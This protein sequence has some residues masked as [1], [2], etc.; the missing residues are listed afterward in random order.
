M[1]LSVC[2]LE[3]LL[4]LATDAAL[5]AGKFINN[6]DR[7]SLQVQSK[8]AGS[9]LSA[10]VVTQ[11]DLDSQAIILAILEPTITQYDIALLTEENTC[12]EGVVTHARFHKDHFWCID[13]L[14]G[15]LPFI[16]GGDGFA[17]SIALVDIT[18]KPIIG[19]VY[20]P[21]TN[22]LYQAINAQPLLSSVLKNR[23]PWQPEKNN[24]V[25]SLY[26]DRSF[27]QDARYPAVLEQLTAQAVQQGLKLQVIKNC[28]AVMNA[29]G[30]LENPPACYVKLPKPQLGGGSLWD[31]SATAAITQALST[32][33]LASS[34]D[35][36]CS[37]S[38]YQGAPLDLNRADSNYMNHRGV[39]YS[40]GL[41][42][43]ILVVMDK[44]EDIEFLSIAK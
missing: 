9:S 10:Q 24:P 21:S 22:D 5:E 27:Q 4:Q 7:K 38:D 14:D 31:F 44:L 35:V 15:T 20:N 30:V 1:K 32:Q 43:Q 16:E 2:Q 28:G 3:Q 12:E 8:Q 19:V 18:G 23:M 33:Y 26:I 36:L 6:V 40:C 25:L 34:S 17:V 29:I 41:I 13:P 42:Q 11:V 37:V 39:L